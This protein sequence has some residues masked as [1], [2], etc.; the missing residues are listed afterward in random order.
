LYGSAYVLLGR[1]WFRR[2][3]YKPWVGC[4]YPFAAMALALF[5]MVTPL[6]QFLLWLAPFGSKGSFSEWIMFAVFLVVPAALVVIF[7]RRKPGQPAGLAVDWPIWAAP[8][9]FHLADWFW[10]AVGGYWEVAG[11]AVAAGAAHAALLGWIWY[12]G[13]RAAPTAGAVDALSP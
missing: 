3:G 11:L 4:V 1:A 9:A 10:I 13:W 2:S 12:R 6:S 7:Q 5:T 8:L